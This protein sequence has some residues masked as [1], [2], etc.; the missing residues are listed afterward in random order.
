MTADK[1][2]SFLDSFRQ[3]ED[4]KVQ[5]E[6]EKQVL[7]EEKKNILL[8][9]GKESVDDLQKEVASIS[10]ELETLLQ[11]LEMPQEILNELKNIDK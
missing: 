7:E 1:V 4:K 3:F 6:A 9:L 11:R 10:A 5:L 2:Q 8:E